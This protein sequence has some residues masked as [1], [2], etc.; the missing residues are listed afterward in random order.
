MNKTTSFGV[1][2]KETSAGKTYL[3]WAVPFEAG[4]LEAIAKDESGRIIA[5]DKVVTAG[6]P[7][8]VKLTA[9]RHVITA[10]GKDLS[11]I[12]VDIV[13][14]EGNIVPTADH[15]VKFSVSGD[16]ELVGV[17]NGNALSIERF[18]DDKRKAFNGKALAIVQSNQNSG[19]IKLS[20]VSSGLAGDAIQMYTIPTSEVNL[21]E[22]AGFERIEVTTRVKEAPKLPASLE[23]YYKDSTVQT[24][25]VAWEAIDPARYAQVGSFTVEGRVDGI[26]SKAVAY[27]TVNSVAAIK[28]IA[29]VTMPG[30]IPELPS[31]VSLLYSNDTTKDVPVLWDAI[32]DQQV[33]N[34][35]SFIVEGSVADTS[36][37]AQAFIRVTDET[38]RVNL[39]L[40]KPGSAYPK[41]AASYTANGDNLAHINDGIKSYSDSPKNRWTSWLSPNPGDSITVDF[42]AADSI[43][44]LNL[45][46]FTD[47][48]T[49]VPGSVKVEYWNGTAWAEVRNKVEPTPYITGENHISFARIITDQ[50]RFYM[51]PSVSGKYS[52][53]TE[54]EV[55]ANQLIKGT[56]AN[57]AKITLDGLPL[58]DFTAAKHNYELI[59]PADAEIPVVEA[60]GADHATITI[61]PAIAIPGEEKIYVTSEDGL[62]ASEYVISLLPEP[63]LKEVESI[64]PVTMVIDKGALPVLPEQILARYNDGSY[65]EVKVDWEAI[66]PD[67]YNQLGEFIVEGSIEGTDIKAKAVII[68]KTALA[69]EHTATAILRNQT[70]KLPQLVTVYFGDGTEEQKAVNWAAIPAGQFDKTGIYE[71]SGSVEGV[72]M[73]ATASIR[74]TDEAGEVKNISL[75]KNG[76]DYPKAEAS[77]TNNGPASKD[78]IESINDGII[79]YNDSPQNRWTNWQRTPR[80]GGDWVSVTFGDFGPVEHDVDNM[81]IHWF[82]DSGTS[83]PASFKIQYKSGDDWVDVT[84]VSANPSTPKANQ[85]NYY[86]FDM[87]RTSAI[88]VDMMPQPGLSLAIT[89]ISIYSKS[90][91]AGSEPVVSDIQVDG[92]SIKDKFVPVNGGYETTI[93][94]ASVKDLPQITATG[95]NNTSITIVP[96]L[97][98]PAAAKV[99]AKSEDGKKTAT[100]LIRFIVEDEGETERL[101]VVLSGPETVQS[102]EQFTVDLGLKNVAAALQAHDITVQYD[103]DTFE[104][105]HARL[106]KDQMQIIKTITDI[107]GEIRFIIASLGE[108]NALRA[109]EI[110]LELTWQAK[111]T[112]Q[113]VKGTIRTAQATISDSAGYETDAVQASLAVQVSPVAVPGSPDV[114]G[115]GKVSIGDLSIAAAHYG[116]TKDSPDWQLAKRA[117]VNGDGVIDIE[118]LAAIARA[119]LK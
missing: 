21:P 37:R 52:A 71:L 88:R 10:D 28:S 35:G 107:P 19:V 13:D 67:L 16:G 110:F 95:E 12:T 50:L 54:V 105:V 41:L 108:Q 11:F 111:A 7:A 85:A 26:E 17:D 61:L 65:A 25:A 45:F 3:E 115:D 91:V 15:L 68:V 64:D 106:K 1:P 92:S 44:N 30:H 87:V 9:D 72:V 20:A 86:T 97:T 6:P 14:R 94:L 112:E 60:I 117:D 33:A 43:D 70:P 118:D 56:T 109:D 102:E 99:I 116:K 42:A 104:F 80:T 75:A 79:S 66:D 53:L 101:A 76:Y 34:K 2:Y 93:K 81:E 74:V 113:A 39:M 46:V 48:G 49:A 114:N 89:E 18:K 36:M 82:A 58:M 62:V 29:A 83:Y 78:T 100:Y 32:T 55:Y 63:P 51:T 69:V 24:K 38:Q 40:A 57:L 5:R 90:A 4:T 73:Q 77:F 103:S 27:V 22:A 31:H 96:V 23:V 47:H 84:N 119:L 59:L 98:A 8:A